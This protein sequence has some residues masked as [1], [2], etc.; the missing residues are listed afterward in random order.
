MQK[1]IAAA[2]RISQAHQGVLDVSGDPLWPAGCRTRRGC[3]VQGLVIAVLW[4]R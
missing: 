2:L 4:R 3:A 1:L